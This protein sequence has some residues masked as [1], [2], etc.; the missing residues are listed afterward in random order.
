M[1]V[2]RLL[3]TV[4]QGF[5]F[6][7]VTRPVLARVCWLDLVLGSRAFL[8]Y[9]VGAFILSSLLVYAEKIKL[10]YIYIIVLDD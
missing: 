10:R 7:S 8:V 9:T 6:A 2:G 1:W 5:V 3:A 4:L